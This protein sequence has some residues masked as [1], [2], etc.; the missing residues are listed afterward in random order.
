MTATLEER[1]K[2]RFRDLVKTNPQI[3]LKQ[4]MN[5]MERR[6]LLDSTRGHSPLKVAD[7]AVVIDTTGRSIEEVIEEIM[8]IVGG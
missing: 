1:A 7:D 2:R 6:D 3:T 5:E 4:V 8:G